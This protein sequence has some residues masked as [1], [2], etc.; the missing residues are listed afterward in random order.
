MCDPV[1]AVRIATGGDADQA[2]EVGQSPADEY[3]VEGCE[4]E[5][6]LKR[7]RG[8]RQLHIQTQARHTCI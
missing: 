5:R 7:R 4:L 6:L 2:G 3:V 8:V 1:E